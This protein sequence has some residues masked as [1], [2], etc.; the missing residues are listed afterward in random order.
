MREF[1]QW[2]GSHEVDR[3]VLTKLVAVEQRTTIIIPGGQAEL[4]FHTSE[5]LRAKVV[6]LEALH[7][8][9]VR[10]ALSTSAEL[11]PAFN[12]GELQASVV[13]ASPAY[14]AFAVDSA[15]SCYPSAVHEERRDARPA[16]VRA[17]ALWVPDPARPSTPHAWCLFPTN[18]KR[19]SESTTVNERS[20]ERLTRAP[21]V[22]ALQVFPRRPRLG[23]AACAVQG[24]NDAGHRQSGPIP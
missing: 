11:V 10:L 19:A 3:T 16:A 1:L 12:F 7:K 15:P 18:L 22:H 6:V 8:G 24:P 14:C 17:Q 23:P 13:P 20:S 2:A 9:F 5:N 4:L 21:V